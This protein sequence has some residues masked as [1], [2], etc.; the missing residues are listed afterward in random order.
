MV[1][2]IGRLDEFDVGIFRRHLVGLRIDPL[3]QHA[4]EQEV[5]EDDDALV[6]ELG[7]MLETG[8]DKRE[9]DT[10]VAGLAPAETKTLPEHPHDLGDVGVG[11]RIGCT[12]T[13]D[14]QHRVMDCHLAMLTIG[15]IKR[16][17]DALTG[18]PDHL[19]V[20]PEFA[21]II[22][23]HTG[24][25]RLIGVEHA[26]DVVL[27]VAGGKQ[28]A[29]NRKHPLD[30]HR[31]QL[32][33]TVGDNRVAEFEI[34]VFDRHVGIAGAQAFCHRCEFAGCVLV[35]AAMATNHDSRLCHLMLPSCAV[36]AR[37]G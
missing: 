28:H 22:D 34:A 6:A 23:D 35:A 1:V 14:H 19:Q 10:R 21:A 20:D 8:T 11:V 36:C 15:H 31:A 9:R 7:G 3:D 18:C 16:F 33:E 5:R 29:G 2:E 12:A 13:D 17:L 4:G 27:G 24:I 30:A 26:R 25:L 37:S 32:V